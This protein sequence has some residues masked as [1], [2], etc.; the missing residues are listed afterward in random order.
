M[1]NWKVDVPQI[2][3][4]DFYQLSEY[5][6]TMNKHFILIIFTILSLLFV[7]RS[8]FSET[9]L[10]S[11]QTEHTADVPLIFEDVQKGITSAN[12]NLFALYFSKQV[13]LRLRDIEEGYYSSN[14][15]H[16]IV[17]NFLN[18]YQ[19][20][21]FRF[22]SEGGNDAVRYATGG[23]TFLS[24][25]KRESFQVYVSISKIEDRWVITQFNVY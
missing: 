13:Y 11:I 4:V 24:R 10:E 2:L 23:G 1:R 12:A 5:F 21:K 22:T 15:T 18:S 6:R 8:S 19:V 16:S 17:Q 7:S 20:I 3:L 9:N 25:N 14:Q